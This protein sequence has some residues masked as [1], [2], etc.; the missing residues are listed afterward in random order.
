MEHSRFDLSTQV[1]FIIVNYE[2]LK[3]NYVFYGQIKLAIF[4]YIL[5]LEKL[6]VYSSKDN[7][8]VEIDVVFN[9]T[10]ALELVL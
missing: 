8:N 9:A 2:K 4:I 7:T 3:K 5:R 6:I 10:S 1:D